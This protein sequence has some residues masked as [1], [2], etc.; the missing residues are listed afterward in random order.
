MDGSIWAYE[1]LESEVAALEALNANSTVEE[2]T[3]LIAG[4]STFIAVRTYFAQAAQA[5]AARRKELLTVR[6]KNKKVSLKDGSTQ[7]PLESESTS[8][9]TPP[10]KLA[11][12]LLI[13]GDGLRLLTNQLVKVRAG[14]E[15][16]TPVLEYTYTRVRVFM[17]NC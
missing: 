3:Q 4:S 17:L 2:T 13:G 7:E 10:Q 16:E 15:S 14:P 9:A 8:V 6:L 12:N 1:R 11:F 5:E